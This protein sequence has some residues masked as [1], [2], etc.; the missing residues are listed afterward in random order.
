MRL[1]SLYVD[2]FGHFHDYTVGPLDSN[3]TVLYGPNEAG[4]STLLA[5]IRTVLFGFPTRGRDDYYPPIAGGKHG[6]RI[7]L[8]DDDGTS[9]TVE[10]FAGPHGGRYLLRAESGDLN[11]DPMAL[12]RLTGHATPDLFRNVFAFSLDEIQ[13]EGLMSDSEGAGRLYSAGMGA[14]GLPDFIRNLANRK[15]ELF[16]PRGSAQEIAK[17]LRDLSIVD[18]RLRTIQDQAQDY[19]N[20]MERQDVILRELRTVDDETSILNIRLAEIGRLQEGWNDWVALEELEARLREIAEFDGFPDS[21]IERLQDLENR[22]R[23]AREDKDE[24]QLEMRRISEAADF[25]VPDESLLDD[26]EHVEAIRRARNSFDSSVRDLPERRDELRGMEEA[27]TDRTGELGDGWD[28]ASLN[29]LDTSLAVRRQVEEWRDRLNKSI[30]EARA[31][32]VR[33]KQNCEQLEELRAEQRQAEDMLLVDSGARAVGGPRPATGRLE[34]LLDDRA[35]VERVRRGR[36]SFDD[37]VGDLPERRAELNSQEADIARQLRDLGKS[38]DESRLDAFDTSM[39]FRQE[40]DDFRKK[41]VAQSD[42]VRRSTE[43]L[44]RAKADLIECRSA[45]EQVLTKAPLEPPP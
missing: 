6:G 11:V 35:E 27:L 23:Q 43:R 26:V 30:G 29:E 25:S 16:R 18:G 7:T 21:P 15:N 9:Y 38:W 10:R 4:K 20:L 37:S 1:H 19:R 14:S 13:N 5:F 8:F 2:G 39:I 28:E 22:L 33:L 41:I 40:V 3:M 24:A 12:Q 32:D 42:E 44:E 34:D 31:A 45:V 17:L 36:G